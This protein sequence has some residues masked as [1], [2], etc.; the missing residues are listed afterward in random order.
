MI[1][2]M[3][4]S[5]N[6]DYHLFAL[7]ALN[8]AAYGEH[9]V[10][11][12]E[13]FKTSTPLVRSIIAKEL[14]FKFNA[15]PDMQKPFWEAFEDIDLGSRSLLL[16]HLDTAP[17]FAFVTLS[18]K[19]GEMSKNQLKTFLNS[20]SLLE[21][22]SATVQNNLEKFANSEIETYGYLAKEFMEDQEP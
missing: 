9:Y 14:P 11:V 15:S 10:Q 13:V 21:N 7:E 6:A 3:L 4:Y 8:D 20:L 16:K 12:A 18:T 1:L 2:D 17:D 22:L 19:L 5:K